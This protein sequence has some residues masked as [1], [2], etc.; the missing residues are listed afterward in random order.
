[1]KTELPSSQK[2]RG[3]EMKRNQNLISRT[4]SKLAIV[5]SATST[6]LIKRK[7]Q[8]QPHVAVGPRGD[9]TDDVACAL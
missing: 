3:S 2:D 6:S 8:V 9:R 1:M 7:Q 5:N 4:V